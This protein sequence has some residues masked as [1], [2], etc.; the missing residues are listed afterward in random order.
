M[1]VLVANTNPDIANLTGKSHVSSSRGSGIFEVWCIIVV[2]LNKSYASVT[3]QKHQSFLLK[4]EEIVQSCNDEEKEAVRLFFEDFIENRFFKL[5]PGVLDF[6][7]EIILNFALHRPESAH[8]ILDTIIRDLGTEL[9]TRDD[10]KKPSEEKKSLFH[11]S[12]NSMNHLVYLE[13]PVDNKDWMFLSFYPE[14]QSAHLQ[15]F[16]NNNFWP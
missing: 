1:R 9:E 3:D 6:V 15:I 5:R 2:R 13:N 7:R 14:N 16:I 8:N 11:K 10:N 12:S 4:I